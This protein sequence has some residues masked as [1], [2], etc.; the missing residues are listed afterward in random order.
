MPLYKCACIEPYMCETHLG[1]HLATRRGHDYEYVEFTLE[2]SRFRCLQ[3]KIKNTL[4]N[5]NQAELHLIQQ[6]K[7]L[8]DSITTLTKESIRKLDVIKKD[9][10][11]Y[12][13]KSK[14]NVSEMP[15]LKEIEEKKI[16]F[17]PSDFDGIRSQI[18]QVYNQEIL[19]SEEDQN[20]SFFRHR[21]GGFW[22]GAVSKDGT[23][24]VTGGV[25]SKIRVWDLAQKKQK[26]VLHGHNSI[27]QCLILIHDSQFIVSGSLDASVRVWSLQHEFQA[28][29]LKGHDGAIYALCYLENRSWILSGDGKDTLIIWDFANNA[30]LRKLKLPGAIRTLNF[31]KNLCNIIVGS[32]KEIFL[33]EL[34]TSQ[35]LK[36]FTGHTDSIWSLSVT[37]DE[38]R[39]VSGSFDKS[40]IIWDFST[41]KIIHQLNGHTD[42]VNSIALSTDEQIIVSGSDDNTVRLWSM[43]TGDQLHKFNNH[44]SWVK[45]IIRVGNN[46]ISLSEDSSIGFLDVSTRELQINTFLKPFET[47]F[48]NFVK[49]LGLITYGSNNEAVIWDNETGSDTK[50][51]KGHERPVQCVEVSQDGRFAISGSEGG[52]KNLIYWNLETGKIVA[53]LKGHDNSVFCATLAR[54]GLTA[55][56]GSGDKTV[57]T[58]DLREARQDS[59]FSGHTDSIYS[60]KFLEMKRLLVSAGNDKKIMI[61]NLRDKSLYCAL[62]GHTNPIWKVIVTD[63]EKF[64]VSGEDFQGIRIW[65]VDEKRMESRFRYEEEARS[66]IIDNKIELDSVKKYLKA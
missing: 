22:C 56:S 46:F 60:I 21:A 20:L 49:S 18:N 13:N 9:C 6:S 12:L 41:S 26:F 42:N 17:K 15:K 25:D 2:D 28:S 38:K 59:V 16:V 55:A 63:D 62:S 43:D 1:K 19:N 64:I 51:L 58:W 40:I 57:R 48:I 4:S 27:V 50:V 47:N 52:K 23:I 33:Y 7:S 39:I 8:I 45:S 54:D 35:S 10:L 3:S 29:I 11:Q 44:S 65:N 32:R 61:W 30:L 14:F 66:W 24:L 5:I 34:E 37:S 31:T 53:E 36:T